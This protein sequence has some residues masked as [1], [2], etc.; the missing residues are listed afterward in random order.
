MEWT[1]VEMHLHQTCYL[2][3]VVLGVGDVGHGCCWYGV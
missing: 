2:D 1:A 3:E